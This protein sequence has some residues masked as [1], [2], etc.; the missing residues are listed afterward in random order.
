MFVRTYYLRSPLIRLF[1]AGL[2]T[3]LLTI[4]GGVATALPYG[5]GQYST[6]NY[7][8]TDC[9]DAQAS[10][11]NVTDQENTP[12]TTDPEKSPSEETGL[13]TKPP[14]A[15]ATTRVGSFINVKVISF[16]LGG[17]SLLAFAGLMINRLSTK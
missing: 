2:V 8:K 13:T 1:L 12:N 10:A 3:L 4:S 5:S 15:D 7:E 17:I 9:S 16:V 6:C 14:T 11:E